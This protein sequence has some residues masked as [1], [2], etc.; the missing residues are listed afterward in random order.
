[1]TY[2]LAIFDFD[3]TLADSFPFFVSVFNDLAA[4]HRFRGVEPA[5]VQEFRRYSIRRMMRHV[6]LPAWKL[7]LV[8][9][10]F[11]AVMNENRAAIA[12]FAGVD[13]LLAHLARQGVMLAVVSSNSYENIAHILGPGNTGLISFF[14]CGTSIFG[15]AAHL[16]R[17]LRKSGVAAADAIYIGDQ[18]AD[19]EAAR[20]ANLASG[21]VAWG[22]GDIISLRACRPDHEFG[23]IADI[24]RII[25]FERKEHGAGT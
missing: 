10:D 19:L 20:D 7:P 14:E 5:A 4:R 18:T 15:K 11:M 22:Y 13:E 6:G 9:R 8:A 16:R 3:G 23:S 12:L 21:A 17:V 24:R 1:M 25:D 2:R